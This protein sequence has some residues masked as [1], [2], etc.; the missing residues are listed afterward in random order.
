MSFTLSTFP[1]LALSAF[2]WYWSKGKLLPVVMF[3]SVFQAASILNLDANQIGVQ[4]AYFLLLLALGQKLVFWS[5]GQKTFGSRPNFISVLLGLFVAYAAVSAFT[6]PWL[7]R[8]V[9]IS[10]PHVGFNVPLGWETSHLNQLFYL[11]L[12]FIL[13]IVAAYKTTA[14]EI[15]RS[16][17]WFIGG[18]VLA[19]IIGIYQYLC[20]KTGLPFPTEYL[21][22]NPVYAIFP[23]YEINGFPRMNATFTEASSAAFS[24]IVALALASWR[25]VSGSISLGRLI[26]A[27]LLAIGLVITISTTGYV[28][29]AYLL[30]IS[31]LVYVFRWKGNSQAR[32][33]KVL[34]AVPVFLLLIT[35][36][37]TSALRESFGA[38][39][40][41]AVLDKQQTESYR[42]RTKWNEDALTAAADADWV[43]T[44][45]GVCRASSLIPTMLANVG[46][47]GVLLFSWVCFRALR[48][49]GRLL[50]I[51]EPMHAS[52]LLALSAALL[53]LAFSGPD[54]SHPILWLL[55]AVAAKYEARKLPARGQRGMRAPKYRIANEHVLPSYP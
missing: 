4:P 5:R 38:L 9:L 47:P 48:P 42:E 52:V 23:G 37:S 27:G 29:L 14:S 32:A 21:H 44:G 50:Q 33:A 46:L 20:L 49:M 55:L 39:L 7:F 24:L 26:Q 36:L 11:V 15:G 12:S 41:T 19:S 10:N 28:C 40:H 2:L 53:D 43:G 30:A 31:S 8:G 18:C 54:P 16:L 45:W 6:N 34:L 51:R 17:E 3:M 25:L 1:L 22:S 35:L 13:Y